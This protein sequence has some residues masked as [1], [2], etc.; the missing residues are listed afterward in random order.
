VKRCTKLNEL[1]EN[2]QPSLKELFG[3]DNDDDDVVAARS[4]G[5]VSTASERLTNDVIRR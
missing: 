5:A 3:S 1:T 4:P 2:M